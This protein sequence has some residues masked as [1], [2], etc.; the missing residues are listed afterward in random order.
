MVWC[1]TMDGK[2]LLNRFLHEDYGPACGPNVCVTPHNSIDLLE[3]E[4]LLVIGEIRDRLRPIGRGHVLMLE[5]RQESVLKNQEFYAH[6]FQR[7]LDMG[8]FFDHQKMMVF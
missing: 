5:L 7:I 6:L 1:V 2:D 3:L 4:R 8:I